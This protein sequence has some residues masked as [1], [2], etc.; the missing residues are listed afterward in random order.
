MLLKI[1]P[2]SRLDWSRTF[3]SQCTYMI[4]VVA[5]DMRIHAKQSTDDGSNRVS[6]IL[7]KCGTCHKNHDEEG[8]VAKEDS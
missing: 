4:K 8:G 1:W 6:E 7:G 3:Y 5:I 2:K